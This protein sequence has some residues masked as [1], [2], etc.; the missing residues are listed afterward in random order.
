VLFFDFWK[1]NHAWNA[2][3]AFGATRVV[4]A[5]VEAHYGRA[6]AESTIV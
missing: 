4:D 2:S 3:V 6:N 1:L 5:G